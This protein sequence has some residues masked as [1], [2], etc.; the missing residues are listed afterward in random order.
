MDDALLV[1][2][3][4]CLRDLLRDGDRL[5]DRDPPALQSLREVLALDQLHDEDVRPRSVR[6]SHALESVEVRDAGVV[7][8]GEDLG[9][10]LETGEAVGVG[11]EGLGEQ[12]ESHVAAQRGVGGAVDLA[13]P[14][15]PESR[16]DTVVG[17]RLAD[18]SADF[19]FTTATAGLEPCGRRVRM[20]KRWPSG[21]TA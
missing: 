17:E 18:H 10:P 1:G 19:Q 13:H 14:A 7:E 16:G 20:R 2:L 9:L 15:G 6:E 5:V 21:A 8:R 4:E 3:F 12:L 11:G